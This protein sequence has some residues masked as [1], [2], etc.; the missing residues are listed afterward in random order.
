MKEIKHLQDIRSKA[1]A[2]DI[3]DQRVERHSVQAIVMLRELPDP[4]PVPASMPM[5]GPSITPTDGILQPDTKV[6]AVRFD[7]DDALA[8]AVNNIGTLHPFE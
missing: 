5:P 6:Y 8:Y 2:R 1:S 7:H 4:P 3:P